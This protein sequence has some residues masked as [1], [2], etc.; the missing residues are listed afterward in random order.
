MSE[1]S[2]R[3]LPDAERPTPSEELQA[4]LEPLPEKDQDYWGDSDM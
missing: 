1:D 2:K 3:E 4:E